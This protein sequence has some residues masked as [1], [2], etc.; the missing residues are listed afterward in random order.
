MLLQISAMTDQLSLFL[1]NSRPSFEQPQSLETLTKE[2]VSQ[3]ERMAIPQCIQALNAIRGELHK[4]SPMRN[5]PVD[6][7]QWVAA[8]SVYANDYN[9]NSV[10]PPEMEL[11]AHSILTDGYTQPIVT[12]P[13]GKGR[14]VVD[15]FHRNRVCKENKEVSARVNNYLPVV[16]IKSSQSDLNDRI[17]ATIRHNRARGKHSVDAM[18]DIEI[19]LKRRNWSDLRIGKELGMDPDEVLRLTQ[20]TG[21]AEVFAEQEFSEAWEAGHAPS[22]SSELLSDVIEDYR[23]KNNGRILHTWENWECYKAGFYAERP[24]A[25]LSNEEGEEIYREFL[26]NSVAF[27]SA[28]DDVIAQWKNSCEHYLTNDRMNRIAWLGQASAAYA[29]QMP[30][31]C[32]GGYNRLTKEQQVEAD[33]I[34][35]QYLNKW[36]EANDREPATMAEALGRTE[37]ELY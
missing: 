6:F 21:L 28:L 15:G 5:E 36:L 3:L 37:A 4:C 30:S 19:E 13:T 24:P 27:A 2:I 7:V 10:A 9:P 22:G 16:S 17:A 29:V 31:G 14:E 35:L 25:G 20:I 1:C 12:L 23:P 11:L 18:S 26:S 32:R 33:A 34:A 8:E